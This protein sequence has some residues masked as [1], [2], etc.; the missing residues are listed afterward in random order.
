MS[1]DVTLLSPYQCAVSAGQNGLKTLF[2]L[3]ENLDSTAEIRQTAWQ[4][5]G[6]TD[7]CSEKYTHGKSGLGYVQIRYYV[8]HKTLFVLRENLDSTAEIRQT[9][10]RVN[11]GFFR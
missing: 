5:A 1:P 3:R 7:S 9:V 6:S 11:D 2:V 4:T 10:G 8:S